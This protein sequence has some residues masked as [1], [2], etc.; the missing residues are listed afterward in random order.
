MDGDSNFS[1]VKVSDITAEI[2]AVRLW[3]NI[4]FNSTWRPQSYKLDNGLKT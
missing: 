4:V 1:K 3:P 2:L